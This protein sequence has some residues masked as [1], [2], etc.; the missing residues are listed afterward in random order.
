MNGTKGHLGRGRWAILFAT[1]AAVIGSAF[2][3]LPGTDMAG[4]GGGKAMQRVT[5][6]PPIDRSEHVRTET[7]VFGMG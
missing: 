6:I 4:R 5:V 2:F 3:L 7:A 1:A